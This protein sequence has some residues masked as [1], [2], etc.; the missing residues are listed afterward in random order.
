MTKSKNITAAIVEPTI[1]PVAWACVGSFMVGA[2][3]G[4]DEEY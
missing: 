3:S 2:I 4:V 1:I